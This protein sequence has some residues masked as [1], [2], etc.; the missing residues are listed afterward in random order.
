LR[1]PHLTIERH[2]GELSPRDKADLLAIVLHYFPKPE[3]VGEIIDYHL[4][5]SDAVILA[6]L[7]G[8][9]I[10]LSLA[11]KLHQLTPYYPRPLD[12][13]F[14]RAL[15]VDPDVIYRGLGKRLMV[16]TMRSLLGWFWFARR[17]AL[18][19]RTQN[20]TVSRL[21]TKFNLMY[22]KPGEHLPAAVLSF[23]QGLLPVLNSTG[24]DEDGRLQGSLEEFK[25]YDHTEIW[26][27]YYNTLNDNYERMMLDRAFVCDNGRVINS[28]K[29]IFFTAYA[30]PWVFL[31]YLFH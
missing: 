17:F 11:S 15:F 13:V 19:C 6:R 27:R 5:L 16:A 26:N 29:L 21:L 22:P 12:V 24:L 30:K 20:P 31:R 7:R 3:V 14:Q 4:S 2:R 18:V 23:G 8:K 28:G 25:N 10:G 1:H 9:I